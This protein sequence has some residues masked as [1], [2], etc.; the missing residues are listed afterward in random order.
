MI[1][2][3]P[4]STLF[5]YTTL[6]RSYLRARALPWPGVVRRRAIPL[7][8]APARGRERGHHRVRSHGLG[9]ARDARLSGALAGHQDQAGHAPDWGVDAAAPAL[10]AAHLRALPTAGGAARPGWRGAVP[11]RGRSAVRGRGGAAAR[12]ARPAGAAEPGQGRDRRSARGGRAPRPRAHAADAPP[13]RVRAF[14]ETAG[15]PR[16]RRAGRGARARAAAQPDLRRT[17]LKRQEPRM[18]GARS[19]ALAAVALVTVGGCR[20][21]PSGPKVT[22]RYHP[23]GGGGYHNARG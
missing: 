4:R 1:R 2:R 9:R 19:L 11:A 18:S 10:H 13:G 16:H 17:L 22:L 3:P 12:E 20:G 8:G 15:R 5:P 23:A 6:F 21:G 14:Q 7:P